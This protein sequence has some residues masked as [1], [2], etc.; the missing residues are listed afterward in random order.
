MRSLPQREVAGMN[1]N[2]ESYVMMK[3]LTL[4]FNEKTMLKY[5]TKALK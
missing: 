4:L 3:L 5:I 2:M 1:K